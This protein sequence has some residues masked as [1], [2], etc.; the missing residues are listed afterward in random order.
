MI[1]RAVLS[2]GSN[3]GDRLAH[4]TSV[5]DRFAEELIAVSRVY[6][7]P[8]WGGVDQDDFYNITLIV[9]GEHQ[10][11][12]WLAI[13]A[14]LERSA[15]RVREIRWGPRTLD[16]DV[17]NVEA[18]GKPVV[19][20]DEQLTLPHPR[21]AQRAFVLVP[22]HEIAP[23]ATLWTTTGEV[24][25]STLIDRLDPAERAGVVAVTALPPAALPDSGVPR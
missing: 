22:W 9:E 5:V 19:S 1:T 23:D 18:G 15:D 2:A 21:A 16:V 11:G 24:G 12:D 10:P 17:I 7:T 20:D 3:V 13:G 6:S 8:P 25:V 4:L 14:E